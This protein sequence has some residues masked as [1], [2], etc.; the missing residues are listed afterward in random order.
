M[1][2]PSLS[3]MCVKDVALSQLV[4]LHR[5]N[6]PWIR[7]GCPL[8]CYIRPNPLPPTVGF[9]VKKTAPSSMPYRALTRGF[10]H[11]LGT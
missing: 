7:E 8:P 9:K 10:V 2:S 5:D 4:L 3:A 11:F 6:T 1:L